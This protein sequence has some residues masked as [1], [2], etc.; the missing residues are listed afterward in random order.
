MRLGLV[1]TLDKFLLACSFILIIVRCSFGATLG[2]LDY[3]TF[4]NPKVNV[5]PLY[6]ISYGNGVYVAAGDWGTVLISSDGTNWRNKSLPISAS[7]GALAFG[8][9]LFVL[10]L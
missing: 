8:N 1:C 7:F 4:V 5:N 3:W 2:P 6:S 9:G 10:Y